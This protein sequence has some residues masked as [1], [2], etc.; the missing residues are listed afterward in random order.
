MG[1]SLQSGHATCSRNSRNAR[2]AQVVRKPGL[3]TGRVCHFRHPVHLLIVPNIGPHA[4]GYRLSVRPGVI[5]Q[6]PVVVARQFAKLR[7]Q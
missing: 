7:P 4:I 6:V 5:R 3:R 2:R 1:S